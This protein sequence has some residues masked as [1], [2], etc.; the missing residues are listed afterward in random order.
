MNNVIYPDKFPKRIL[1]PG[2]GGGTMEERLARIEA[3]LPYLATKEDVMAVKADVDK[4]GR[5]VVMWNVG[6]VFAAVGIVFAL[7]K[8]L[9]P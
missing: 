9:G 2:G 5:I 1:P 7:I 8:F 6:T 3:M 4:M